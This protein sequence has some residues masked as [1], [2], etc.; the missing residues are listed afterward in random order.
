MPTM[1]ASSSTATPLHAV[2]ITGEER[3][4]GEIGANVREGV[5][6]MLGT[7]RVAFFGV[8]PVCDSWAALQR[9]L[10]LTS[11]VPQH[12]CWDAEDL[13]VTVRWV[14]CDLRGRAS[15]CRVSFI[16]TMCDLKSCLRMISSFESHNGMQFAT[17]TK[18]RP[19]V[20]WETAV[21]LP[22]VKEHTLHVPRIDAANGVND[23][24][25]IGGRA[26][27]HAYLSRYKYVKNATAMAAGV[28]IRLQ[29]GTTEQ[30]LDAALRKEHIKVRRIAS[31]V[32]CMHNRK[33]LLSHVG[34]RGCIGRVRCRTP[35]ETL[36][37]PGPGIKAASAICHNVTCAAMRRGELVGS[38]PLGPRGSL[39]YGTWKVD[40]E[41]SPAFWRKMGSD[42]NTCVDV[43]GGKQLFHA[44]DRKGTRC[45]RPCEWPRDA[46]TGEYLQFATLEALPG[47]ILPTLRSTTEPA[48]GR[49]SYV[50]RRTVFVN[51]SLGVWP[52]AGPV[53]NRSV[54][55]HAFPG[56]Q[57]MTSASSSSL[58]SPLW[59][60]T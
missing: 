18:L 40:R 60:Q 32:H 16:Q 5:L 7:A 12:K 49:C 38:I 37:V 3:S 34:H 29:G 47:C 20:F 17:I 31:W 11:V 19:D 10:P 21:Y 52:I 9:L 50:S 15:D 8:K 30:F 39:A 33:M 14:H 42:Q 44:C 58:S 45:D 28:G 53:R 25:A 46:E 54:N 27:M 1:R 59:H 23:K 41:K 51:D 55:G 6:R 56:G 24:L 48:P 2:C 26:A 13:H 35:C 57:R 36:L 22:E 4:F 43:G